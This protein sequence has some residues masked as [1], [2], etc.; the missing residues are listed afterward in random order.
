MSL[1]SLMRDRVSFVKKDG[2]PV[3]SNISANVS[4]KQI[5]TLDVSL[6]I[7]VGD[8]FERKLPNGLIETF[9]V[10]DPGYH[11]GI[12]G[13]QAHYQVKVRRGDAPA[14]PRS[15]TANFHG[16]NSRIN[17]NTNDSS[18]NVASDLRRDDVV[19]LASQ[20]RAHMSALPIEQHKGIEGP[21]SVL[22][23]EVA[24]PVLSQSKIR[25]A[26]ETIGVVAEGAAGN[27]VASGIA[28]LVSRMLGGG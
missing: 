21:L 1:S 13:I 7:E 10:T 27:L 8:C 9:I 14:T 12:G 24:N 2:T 5:T 22:E 23:A 16:P 18:V 25:A 15:I 26:L 20:V 19:A 28:A 6:R 11:S 17:I 4:S 3:K